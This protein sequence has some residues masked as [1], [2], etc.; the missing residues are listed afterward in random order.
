MNNQELIEVRGGVSISAAK[1]A[2]VYKCFTYI[3]N[4]GTKI[5]SAIR[6]IKTKRTC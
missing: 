4:L 2:A 5:G 1:I 6:Y 3:H